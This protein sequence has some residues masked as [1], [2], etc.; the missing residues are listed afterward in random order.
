MVDNSK[1]YLCD[2]GK[3][4]GRGILSKGWH[5]LFLLAACQVP[6]FSL[7]AHLS[8]CFIHTAMLCTTHR[9]GIVYIQMH[10]IGMRAQCL[11]YVSDR[12]SPT[13]FLHCVFFFIIWNFWSAILW[14]HEKLYKQWNQTELS[15][16][17]K[18]AFL[19][20]LQNWFLLT[21]SCWQCKHLM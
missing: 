21:N 13:G 14:T 6:L 9:E 19:G 7:G 4:Y 3:E 1:V 18:L 17:L 20:T 15:I 11:F 16:S 5:F 12:F 10:Y 2:I 8:D